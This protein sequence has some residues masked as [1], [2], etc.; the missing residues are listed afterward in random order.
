MTRKKVIFLLLAVLSLTVLSSAQLTHT[1]TTT[2][3]NGTCGVPHSVS[4]F[5]NWVYTDSF[6]AHAFAG[7]SEVIQPARINVAGKIESCP[8]DTTT[9]DVDSSDGERY[10]LHAVG[11]AGTTTLKGNLAPKY[12]V[13]AVA[14]APPGARSSV[15]YGTSTLLG[16]ST[17]LMNSFSSGTS[18]SI[19]VGVGVSIPGFSEGVTTTTTS[20]FTEEADTTSTVSVNKTT[21]TDISVPGPASSAAGLDHDFDVVFIWLNPVVNITLTAPASTSVQWTGY[22]SDARDPAIGMDIVPLQLAQLKN[23]A[24]ITNPNTL[25]SLARAWAGTGQGLTN[26]DLLNIAARDPF[27]NPAYTVTIPAGSTCTADNRFC[28]TT[29]QD[30]AY[31][32]PAP[33]GQPLTEKFSAGYQTTAIAGQSAMDTFQVSFTTDLNVKSGFVTQFSLDLKTTD[34]FTWS[35][36]WSS[37]RTNTI[38][39]TASFS[40]TGPATSD[41][42]AGPTEFNIF[43]D[44][45]YGTFMF[46][47][48]N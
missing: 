36:K 41:N 46:S 7:T 38:G 32:N 16:T 39:Q 25:Q 2:T 33:G 19:S 43:Q 26:A 28:S 1:T 14:Y 11:A 27:S 29:L 15:D 45:V 22:S 48:A 20:A 18:V 47:P 6:G 30:L 9:L 44:N 31:A 40:V 4:K 10:H 3:Q 13:L 12:M 5:T 35:N 34:M 24:L 42:Y 23:P 37:T 8:G 17:S 21:S